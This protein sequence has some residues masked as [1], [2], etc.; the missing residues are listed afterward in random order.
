M[1][2]KLVVVFL[3]LAV[4]C[5]SAELRKL[6][7]QA[8]AIAST[9]V[10]VPHV[11]DVGPMNGAPATVDAGAQ[12]PPAGQVLPSKARLVAPFRGTNAH[13][14]VAMT[15]KDRTLASG[16]RRA[17][18]AFGGEILDESRPVLVAS[19]T[20]LW[21]AIAALRMVERGA[22]SL[23]ETVREALP[24]LASRPWADSTVRELM[25]HV[26]RVPEFD[27]RGGYY[28][29]DVDLS[30]PVDVLSKH[31]PRDWAEKRGVYKYRNAE[32]ALVGAILG[33]R[34]K[35]PAE[36]VLEREV[37]EPSGMKNAGLLV[38]KAPPGL[39]LTP[40]GRIRPQNFFTAGAGYASVSDLL[41]FLE[42]LAGGELLNDAS[43]ALLFDGAA[44]RGQG[45]LGCWAYSFPRPD[46]G[47]TRLI[48]RPGSFGNV[49][50][51]SAFFPDERR[52]I[53]AWTADALEI[54][55]PRA[56][57]GIGFSLARLALE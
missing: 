51:F 12:L 27:E 15:A 39:D 16:A 44:D 50:L 26:S 38:R 30:A 7:A 33:E 49:R 6:P 3:V 1:R 32:F 34:A 4:G 22:L 8:D 21:T 9:A 19:F 43:K 17:V 41:S 23:D 2:E 55:R 10:E 24:A 40:V 57:K 31:I 52:A 42:A 13:G 36:R 20:K 5:R 46:G 48:E 54:P 11:S 14:F 45:A 47:T 53:V 56:G 18:S 29:A 37:F 25:A 35:L 28:R